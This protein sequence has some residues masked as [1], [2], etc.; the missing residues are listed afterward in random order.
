MIMR[1]GVVAAGA[2][3]AVAGCLPTGN[4]RFPQDPDQV[5]IRLDAPTDLAAATRM[6][7]ETCARNG[8]EARFLNLVDPDAS[9]RLSGAA[10][11]APDALFACE[12]RR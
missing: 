11:R 3:L 6:A 9:G 1:V 4:P 7:R 5:V 8:R 2:V 10:P 12:P